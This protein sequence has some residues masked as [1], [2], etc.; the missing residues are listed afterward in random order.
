MKIKTPEVTVYLPYEDERMLE[1]YGGKGGRV[2]R[3]KTILMVGNNIDLSFFPS[4]IKLELVGY[5]CGGVQETD[6][7]SDSEV[8]CVSTKLGA[9]PKPF[10]MR[11]NING[12]QGFFTFEDS[13]VMCHIKNP[14]AY[15]T[16]CSIVVDDNYAKVERTPLETLK[17]SNRT[18]EIQ[19]MFH[20]H[21]TEL[22]KAT[23]RKAKTVDCGELFYANAK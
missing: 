3:N 1:E 5:E 17:Y 7:G 20:V 11:T 22:V 8:I 10:L 6:F 18:K 21:L 9:A 19:I 23:F 4:D 16:L 15:L 13:C 12:V 2:V 14:W